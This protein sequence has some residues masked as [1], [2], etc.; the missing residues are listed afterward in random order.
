[1]GIG[2]RQLVTHYSWIGHVMRA[3]QVRGRG[4]RV[5]S[6]TSSGV[7]RRRGR[8]RVSGSHSTLSVSHHA[9]YRTHG[10]GRKPDVNGMWSEIILAFLALATGFLVIGDFARTQDEILP[11]HA[12]ETPH[13][14][15][16][17][18]AADTRGSRPAPFLR[19]PA[20]VHDVAP[21]R[22]VESIGQVGHG[23]PYSPT[24]PSP[25]HQPSRRG[26][27]DSP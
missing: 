11:D 15:R 2:V 8:S 25:A 5:G 10:P 12:N 3:R 19:E 7:D 21:A 20:D 17:R 13:D 6:V 9:P 24:G 14:V 1:M 27:Q 23:H 26:L 4:G 22:R 18:M 16:P